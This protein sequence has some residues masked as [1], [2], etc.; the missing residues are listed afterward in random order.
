[1]QIK[2]CP[3]CAQLVH[4]DVLYSQPCWNCGAFVDFTPRENWAQTVFRVLDVRLTKVLSPVFDGERWIK[5][6]RRALL[7]ALPLAVVM[8][9]TCN[10]F[11]IGI[12]R[13]ITTPFRRLEINFSNEP[14]SPGW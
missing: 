14:Q 8:L 6:N 3:H 1:M 11:Q 10:S 13:D 12:V 7:T 5:W 4:V 2:K 9:L